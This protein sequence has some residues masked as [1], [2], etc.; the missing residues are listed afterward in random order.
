MLGYF[1]SSRWYQ[2]AW[3]HSPPEKEDGDPHLSA[4][5]GNAQSYMGETFQDFD[6]YFY[7]R[8]PQIT[9]LDRLK[10]IIHIL[11]SFLNLF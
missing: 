5:Q 8:Q 6:I 4:Q 7:G 9:K 2:A 1:F 11:Y 3:K 10:L